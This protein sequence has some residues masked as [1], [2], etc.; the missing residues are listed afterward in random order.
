MSRL[1]ELQS[2]I[3]AMSLGRLAPEELA[4]RVRDDRPIPAAQRLGIY[5][6]NTLLGLV[7]PL[8]ATFPVVAQLVGEDF[9]LRLAGDFVRAHPPARP[10]LLAYGQDFPAFVAGYEAAATVPY[11][12]DVARLELAWNFAY[13]APDREPLPPQALAAF[14]PEQLETLLLTP[15]PSLRFVASRWPVMAIWQ[16][17]Q[18]EDGQ[19]DDQI[20]R[21]DLEAGGDMLLVYRPRQDTLI[22]KVGAGAF[23][24]VMALAAR[25]SLAA[26]YS[27]ALAGDPDFNVAGELS[28]LLAADL[29]AEAIPS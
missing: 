12:A 13:N 14:A 21:I 17:H 25:Q 3:A 10:E 26:A 29:F 22:R 15:H 5:R 23:A 27:S 2:R 16:A 11:L 9:F 7:D 20:G 4:D 24:F 18:A 6:N 8:R 19:V 1:R 28:A